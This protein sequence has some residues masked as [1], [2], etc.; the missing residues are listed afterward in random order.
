MKFLFLVEKVASYFLYFTGIYRLVRR[1]LQ[2][3]G[4]AIVLVYH[5]VLSGSRRSGEMVGEAAFDW[6]MRYLR[7]NF[8]PVDWPTMSE[9]GEGTGGIEVLV[10][11]DDGYHDNFTRALPVMARYR[12][13]GVY[14]LVTDF[15][16]EG[17]RVGENGEKEG[18]VPTSADLRAAQESRWVTF[19][20]H[21]AS[22][23][24]V[25]RMSPDDFDRELSRSQER[26]RETLGVTPE[27]F[28][29]PRG[30][31]GDVSEG[32]DQVLRNHGFKAAFTMIPGRIAE[33]SSQF[34][35]PRIGVSHV[36]D[37]IVFKV[38]MLGLLAPLVKLK[39]AFGA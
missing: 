15:V 10:T 4:G 28:A 5:R 12:I 30:R 14:F 20:N 2:T 7:E 36:N 34:F 24:F 31:P 17:R 26:F 13:P 18:E 9:S 6:Q 39:N 25:S 3:Q 29:Y 1:R 22:H 16:F 8:V 32:A 35:L 11:F 27:L 23:A 21:T 38:K 19:G 37:P 33:N